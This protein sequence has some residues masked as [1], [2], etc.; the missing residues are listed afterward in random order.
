MKLLE[1]N[2]ALKTIGLPVAYESFLEHVEMPFIIYTNPDSESFNAD[3]QTY[4][5]LLDVD[6]ELYSPIRDFATEA[7]IK[8]LLNELK[9]PFTS[10]G[11]FIE[12]EEMYQRVFSIR[13][14]EKL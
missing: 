5:E 13:L 12:E 7:K 4:A 2:A 8:K 14:V 11:A 3:N 9:L 1:F 6:I 10:V